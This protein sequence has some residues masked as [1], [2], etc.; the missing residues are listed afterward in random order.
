M[1]SC[2]KNPGIL[3]ADQ[4]RMISSRERFGTECVFEGIAGKDMLEGL[5]VAGR[6]AEP[7]QV[8][9]LS[10]RIHAD[11]EALIKTTVGSVPDDKIFDHAEL[12]MT[13]Y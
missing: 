1:N 6:A 9:L 11:G 13:T 4:G 7:G 8:N 12:P 3:I 10:Q 2:C 5:L